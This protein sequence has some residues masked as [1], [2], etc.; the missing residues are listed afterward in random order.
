MGRLPLILAAVLLAAP[1]APA[2]AAPR[3]AGAGRT[4]GAAAKPAA[5][6][7]ASGRKPAAGPERQGRRATVRPKAVTLAEARAAMK[8]LMQDPQKRR[9]RDRWER[10]IRGLQAAATGKDAAEG[11]LEA[12]RARYALYRWSANEADRD[13]ALK[14]AKRSAALGSRAAPAFA[15]AVRREAGDE[16]PRSARTRPSPAKARPARPEEKPVERPEALAEAP[17]DPELEAAVADLKA[18]PRAPAAGE[19]ERPAADPAPPEPRTAEATE[20]RAG[21]SAD[22]PEEGEPRPIRRV[23]VDAGHGGHDPGAIGPSR[24]REKDVTLAMARRLAAKL[25]AAGF[26]VVMTRS[27]DRYVALDER[28]SIANA[29]R[30]D[31]F[32]SIHANANP[33]RTL[34][35]VETWVLNVADDRY[36]ARLAARE[37]GADLEE[38]GEGTQAQRILTDLDAQAA[39]GASRKLALGIQREII[40]ASRA[41]FGETPDLGVKASLFYVLLGARMPAVLVETAFISNRREEQRLASAAYQEEVAAAISRAVTQFAQ[42]ATRVARAGPD[43][44]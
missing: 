10:A 41:R 12:A 39:T 20:P 27:D 33:R 44:R 19:P 28:T 13:E 43:P 23:V 24:V 15:A 16:E 4:G 7:A 37:N 8:A 30:G 18:A 40:G 21:G 29:R 11:T 26:E 34:A 42:G 6:P 3:R 38:A 35:G 22:G 9:Y 17:P 2:E 1:S 32:V 5:K 36:A 14:L 31:L 25:K